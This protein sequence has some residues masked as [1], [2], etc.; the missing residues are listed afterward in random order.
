MQVACAA[1]VSNGGHWLRIMSSTKIYRAAFWHSLPSPWLQQETLWASRD[2]LLCCTRTCWFSVSKRSRVF[3]ISF[4]LDNK[5]F[6]SS[7]LS[8][9][10][11]S[12]LCMVVRSTAKCFCQ[13]IRVV[14]SW[15]TSISLGWCPLQGC[16]SHAA[17]MLA[18]Q[19]NIGAKMGSP[20]HVFTGKPCLNNSSI[21][22]TLL[23]SAL[24]YHVHTHWI[25]SQM[26]FE[27]LDSNCSG[28]QNTKS[29]HRCSLLVSSPLLSLHWEP[30]S[31]AFIP[32]EFDI[33]WTYSAFVSDF[34]PT[35]CLYHWGS[36][37]PPC[38]EQFRNVFIPW[39][40]ATVTPQ[41]GEQVKTNLLK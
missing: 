5:L 30:E 29:I 17:L 25:H 22:C 12:G 2:P 32:I 37:I 34:I 31:S 7:R 16:L 36:T 18:L 3:F 1:W 27:L 6:L 28:S 21:C 20:E 19:K 39:A 10:L 24:R 40:M 8:W 26:S 15:T 35:T 38:H 41:D 23:L 13:R 33:Y 11:Q 9:G 4:P 14:G